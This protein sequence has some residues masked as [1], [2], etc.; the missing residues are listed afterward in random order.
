MAIETVCCRDVVDLV[1]RLGPCVE[2][3]VPYDPVR[4]RVR[5]GTAH[6]TCDRHN[7]RIVRVAFGV[8][9]I[10]AQRGVR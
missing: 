3:Q 4:V 10:A 7:H 6:E 1:G 2:I 9:E 8:S 5:F